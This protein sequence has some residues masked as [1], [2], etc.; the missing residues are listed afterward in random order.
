[1]SEDKIVTDLDMLEESYAKYKD[2]SH[3]KARALLMRIDG[4]KAMAVLRE[5]I[6]LAEE[7][8]FMNPPIMVRFQGFYTVHNNESS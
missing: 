1:M 4:M 6:R 2:K 8:M 5:S 7:Q 3:P